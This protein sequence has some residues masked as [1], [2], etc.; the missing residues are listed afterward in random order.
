L[1]TEN[2]KEKEKQKNNVPL[3][4]KEENIKPKAQNERVEKA[5]E[6]N[7]QEKNIRSELNMTFKIHEICKG[8]LIPPKEENFPIL[9]HNLVHKKKLVNNDMYFKPGQNKRIPDE[10]FKKS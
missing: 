7:K 6:E 5:Q 1:N 2:L 3:E 4:K 8:K 9:L 10:I